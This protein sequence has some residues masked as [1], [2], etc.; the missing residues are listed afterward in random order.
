[1]PTGN[2]LN[3]KL[4]L[5]NFSESL[6][7]P[8]L[9]WLRASL[10]RVKV[11]GHAT[12]LISW[13]GSQKSSSNNIKSLLRLYARLSRRTLQVISL[14]SEPNVPDVTLLTFRFYIRKANGLNVPTV[15]FAIDNTS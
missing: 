6:R 14:K 5:S 3:R 2:V 7:E 15:A 13:S 12:S 10:A 11:A 8:P 9:D 1:M 4:L